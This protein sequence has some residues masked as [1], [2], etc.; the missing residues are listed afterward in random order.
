[1][2]VR[3]YLG[4]DF[5]G[6]RDG[7][8]VGTEPPDEETF[9]FD[10]DEGDGIAG[11]RR[12]VQVVGTS[13]EVIDCGADIYEGGYIFIKNKGTAT[14]RLYSTSVGGTPFA[15]LERDDIALYKGGS[16]SFQ[17][18]SVASGSGKI[19]VFVISGLPPA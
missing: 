10:G 6:T 1:M 19:E 17:Y 13:V 3:A 11:C 5:G 4:L 18:A 14:V 16:T 12:F 7:L 9:D 8:G 2:K 15:T